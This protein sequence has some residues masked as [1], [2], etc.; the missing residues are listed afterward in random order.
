LIHFIIAP[1]EM[2]SK[3]YCEIVNMLS[4]KA[5]SLKKNKRRRKNI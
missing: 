4:L 3:I 5:L 2:I 1:P